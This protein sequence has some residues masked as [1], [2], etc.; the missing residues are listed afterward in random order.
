MHC[1]L[2]ETRRAD[3]NIDQRK[4]EQRNDV[5]EAKAR[6]ATLRPSS[7]RRRSSERRRL[8]L[9]PKTPS[10]GNH[11]ESPTSRPRRAREPAAPVVSCE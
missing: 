3:G 1:S 8:S 10:P 11:P 7:N 2:S 6:G 9:L 4:A 5:C